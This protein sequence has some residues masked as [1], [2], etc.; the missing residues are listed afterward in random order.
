MLATLCWCPIFYYLMMAQSFTTWWWWPDLSPTHKFTN[1]RHQHRCNPKFSSKFLKTDLKQICFADQF[2][3]NE[4]CLGIFSRI[5]QLR[6]GIFSTFQQTDC[7]G[8]AATLTVVWRCTPSGGELFGIIKTGF[9]TESIE[10][11]PIW[12]FS[13]SPQPYTFPE[14]LTHRTWNAPTETDCIDSGKFTF[15]GAVTFWSFP[16]PR[17]WN[18]PCKGWFL[19]FLKNHKYSREKLQMFISW[20]FGYT[21]TFR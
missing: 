7:A 19:Y 18:W 10:S 5:F 9:V 13:L 11:T 12:F 16:W 15:F 14:W 6:F 2:S 17:R 3:N 21:I 1:I 4:H 20:V 8:P